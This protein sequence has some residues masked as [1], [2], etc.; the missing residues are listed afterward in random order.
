[1]VAG[2]HSPVNARRQIKTVLAEL[3]RLRSVLSDLD[4][5]GSTEAISEDAVRA[6]LRARR[7]RDV[8]FGTELFADPAWDLLLE[9]YAVSLE[10][11]Q[12]TIIRLCEAAS[13]APTTGLRWLGHL[14]S[15]GLVARSRDPRDKRLAVVALTDLGITKMEEYFARPKLDRGPA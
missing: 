8:I 4:F 2:R 1:M 3:T 11:E 15:K 13:V 12:T 10:D 9:L 14:E 6:M 5:C 7:R